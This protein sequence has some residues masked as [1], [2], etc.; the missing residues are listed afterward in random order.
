MHGWGTDDPT[1]TTT[2]SADEWYICT[3]SYNKSTQAMKIYTNGVLESS[4]TNS[5]SGVTASSNMNW[6]IG[7]VPGGWQSVT[8]SNVNVPIFK[9]YNRILSDSEVKQNFNAY[10]KRFGI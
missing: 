1:G 9:V 10:R 2:I 5:Q 8:Y 3:F 7:T 4:T 6:Y